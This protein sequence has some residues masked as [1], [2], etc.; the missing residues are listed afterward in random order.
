MGATACGDKASGFAEL[1]LC[2]PGV[3]TVQHHVFG[4]D[5]Q[6]LKGKIAKDDL[7]TGV[8]H[9]TVEQIAALVLISELGEVLVSQDTMESNAPAFIQSITEL[10]GGHVLYFVAHAID[11]IMLIEFALS[12]PFVNMRQEVARKQARQEFQG[13]WK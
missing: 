9:N 11:R 5:L 6:I 12:V 10:P 7:G 3:V 2:W 1:V 8:V 13:V 4:K